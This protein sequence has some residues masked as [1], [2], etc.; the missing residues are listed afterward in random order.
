MGAS[1]PPRAAQR[2]DQTGVWTSNSLKPGG[3]RGLATIAAFGLVA[4]DSSL[5]K[6]PDLA[7]DSSSGARTVV[8]VNTKG[9]Q[10]GPTHYE[11]VRT[12][13]RIKDW[14]RFE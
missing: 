1:A 5:K 12:M 10:K 11:C 6:T 14:I 3:R 9:L 2:I 8:R 4:V 7:P 13:R